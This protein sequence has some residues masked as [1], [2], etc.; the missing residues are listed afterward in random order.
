MYVYFHHPLMYYVCGGGLQDDTGRMRGYVSARDLAQLEEIFPRPARSRCVLG[1]G[2]ALLVQGAALFVN[3]AD[4][5]RHLNIV[6][7]NVRRLIHN[8]DVDTVT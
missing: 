2:G 7:R 5:S 3:R 8:V 1:R 6:T 4:I